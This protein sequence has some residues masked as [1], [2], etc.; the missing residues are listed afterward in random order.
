[1]IGF[2]WKNCSAKI[3]QSFWWGDLVGCLLQIEGPLG[4]RYP[5]K[6]SAL[7]KLQAERPELSIGQGNYK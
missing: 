3:G 4:L 6:F 2:K 5:E 1:M 7:F